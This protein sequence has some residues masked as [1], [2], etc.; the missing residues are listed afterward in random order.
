MQ[1]VSV[2]RMLAISAKG[3][4]ACL[5]PPSDGLAA[6]LEPSILAD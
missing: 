1:G 3:G 2:D 5:S 4:T 6:P